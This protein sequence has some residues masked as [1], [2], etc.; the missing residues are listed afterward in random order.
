MEIGTCTMRMIKH[1]FSNTTWRREAPGTR[2][3]ISSSS[4]RL[5]CVSTRISSCSFDGPGECIQDNEQRPD[6]VGSRCDG[7]GPKVAR[8]RSVDVGADVANVQENDFKP[9]VSLP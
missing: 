2:P 3:A 9:T 8:I 1:R 5:H 7:T 6:Y 4:A